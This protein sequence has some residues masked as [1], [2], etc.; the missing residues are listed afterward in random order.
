[1]PIEKTTHSQRENARLSTGPTSS[2]GKAKISHN[3]LETGLTENRD[4]FLAVIRGR[5]SSC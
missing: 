2:E 5:W 4:W 1:M 3:A